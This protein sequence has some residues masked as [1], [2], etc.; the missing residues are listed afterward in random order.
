MKNKIILTLFAFIAITSITLLQSCS[1]LRSVNIHKTYT[2]IAFVIPSPQVAGMIELEQNVTT[3]LQQLA[4]DNNFDISK[5]ES[6]TVNSVTLRIVD[7]ALVPYTFNIVDNATCSLFADGETVAEIGTED[8]IHDSPTEIHFDLSS[9]DVAKYLKA[10]QFKVRMKINTNTAITHDIP[11]LATLD[12][13]F[14][15]KPLK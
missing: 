4:K 14:K 13:S 7:S 3:D 5:I 11:M 10:T 15:V 8:A 12:C 2:D 9:I 6:A 1:Q